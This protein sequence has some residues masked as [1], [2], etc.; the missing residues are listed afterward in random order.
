MSKETILVV[1]DN[2]QLADFIA[3][4]LLP[5]LGYETQ[6]AHNGGSALEMIRASQP[7]LMLLDLE[8]PDGTG[9]EIL[10]QLKNEGYNIPTI[11]CTAHGS[12]QIAADAFRLG[13]EDYLIKP[14]DADI[15]E[16]TV[17]RALTVTRL[18]KETAR[19]T[20]QLKEQVS[21]LNVLSKI[22]QSVTSTLDPDE[23]LRR[24]VEAGVQ[25]TQAEEGFLALLDRSS[26]Q[27]YVRAGKNIDEGQIKTM[28]LPVDDA[29]VGEVIRSGR[30]VRTTGRPGGQPVK[31]STG[32]LVQSLLHVPIFSKGQLLGVLSVDNRV[33]KQNFTQQDESMLVSLADYAS[34][35]LEN[36]GLYQQAK[37][38]ITKRKRTEQALRESEERYARAVQGAN[39]GIWDWNLKNNQVYYSTR[40]KSMLGYEEGE[41]GNDPDEWF[42]RIHPKDV[43]KVKLALSA[44]I[45]GVTAHFENE[46]RM[47]HMDGSYRW[48]LSRGLAVR[49]KDGTASRIAGSQ[50]DISARKAAEAKLLHDAFYDRL[51]GLPNRAL[52][53]DR[54]K[55][56]IERA[57]RRDDYTFA[58]LFLD[59]DEFKNINDSF[60]HPVGDQLLVAISDLLKTNLRATDTVARLGGDEFVILLEDI[61]DESAAMSISEWIMGKFSSPIRLVD[62]EVFVTTS[63]G[64]V[65]STLEYERP[66]DM[67]RDA[68]IA[69]YAAKARGKAFY[70]IF[71]PA[72]RERIL[73]RVAMEADL[74]QALQEQQLS[75]FYQPIVSFKNGQLVGFEALLRWQHP[76]RG[77]IQPLEFIPLAQETGLIIPVDQWVIEEACRQV[78]EWQARFQFDP[79]LKI[80]VNIANSLIAQTD[81]T[82][83]IKR[84]LQNTGMD[85]QNLRL[86]ITESAVAEDNGPMAKIITELNNMGVEVQIDNFGTGYSSLIYLQKFPVAALKI[87]NTFVHRLQEQEGNIE[88]VS[89]II[90]LAHDLG[91]QA[92]AEGIE[93]EAQLSQLKAMGCDCG[94][95]FLLSPPL[96]SEAT[97][98][99]LADGEIEAGAFAPW[100]GLLDSV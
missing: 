23:V 51:T 50:T 86:E 7:S 80:S 29:L 48:M 46:H 96:N 78:Q 47:K 6:T 42:I 37:H 4:T 21:W 10:H 49:G 5:S 30:P 52:F 57:K 74:R 83:G 41:I 66:E 75:V 89:T 58:V 36:A 56:A 67:L 40:W 65:V 90:D 99:M 11:L 35:A 85:K 25:L 24:I 87:D 33:R 28:R 69:M 63:I 9:L 68:D 81:L 88:I 38:E 26:G 39:D 91:M 16:A 92:F 27:F 70:E 8:L 82:G 32:F 53:M 34:V 1:D 64:I 3:N 15:L 93:T 77:F 54:L 94:Q 12:E 84:I 17:S 60:G 72:M 95:G 20:E 31:V 59:L 14:V 18:R 61:K 19:L 97:G 45:R 62:Y 100:E 13:V 44:H 76:E 55:N 22:G 98:A 71:D 2:R 43:E 73:N 79:P